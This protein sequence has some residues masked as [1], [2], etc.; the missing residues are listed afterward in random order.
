VVGVGIPIG[1]HLETLLTLVACLLL[2]PTHSWENNNLKKI[3]F[4]SVLFYLTT[5]SIIISII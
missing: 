1:E 2:V 3:G 4:K 5:A